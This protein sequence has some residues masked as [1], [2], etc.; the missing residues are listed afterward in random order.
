MEQKILNFD[1]NIQEGIDFLLA[2][3]EQHH[4]AKIFTIRVGEQQE[5]K[6]LDVLIVF[7][8]RAIL[9]G[10]ILVS[11]KDGAPAMNIQGNYI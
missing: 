10:K 5:D 2:N 6:S 8:D 3:I 9:E 11:I 1:G 4:G 7:E